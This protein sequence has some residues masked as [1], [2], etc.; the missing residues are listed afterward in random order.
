MADEPET[1]AWYARR[2]RA[3]GWAAAGTLALA[4]AALRQPHDDW[5]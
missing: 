5:S 3:A 1:A 4:L 2:R